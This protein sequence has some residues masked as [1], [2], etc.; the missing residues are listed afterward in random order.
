MVVEVRLEIEIDESLGT[1]DEMNEYIAFE[2]GYS[3]GVKP[4]NPFLL[5]GM[6][7]IDMDIC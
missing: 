7:I 3:G 6:E 5:E 2:L 1:Q 4:D